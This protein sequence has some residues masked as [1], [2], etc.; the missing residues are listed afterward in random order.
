[1]SKS[2]GL[3]AGFPVQRKEHGPGSPEDLGCLGNKYPQNKHSSENQA[4]RALNDTLSH[5][6]ASDRGES[7][8]DDWKNG[9]I[10]PSACSSLVFASC[11]L[12]RLPLYM[13]YP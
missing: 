2:K 11:V 3:P 13:V 7:E 4:S 8:F 12:T 9:R 6:S 5:V 10:E 1:M